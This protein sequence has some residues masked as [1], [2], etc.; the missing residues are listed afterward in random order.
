MKWSHRCKRC[1]EG[2]DASVVR[3]IYC[4]PKCRTAACR[5]RQRKKEKKRVKKT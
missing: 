4:S 1:K 5:Q 2:F 3:A